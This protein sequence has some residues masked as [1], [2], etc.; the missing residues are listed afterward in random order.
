MIMYY[1]SEKWLAKS[2]YLSCE[3]FNPIPISHI[4]LK[5]PSLPKTLNQKKDEV[6]FLNGLSK[7][8]GGETPPILA[9]NA[10]YYRQR[11]NPQV[12]LER[13]LRRQIAH[14]EY[15]ALSTNELKQLAANYT[16]NDLQNLYF[17]VP[18]L[19]L[20]HGYVQTVMKPV[21]LGQITEIHTERGFYLKL[22]HNQNITLYP[23]S[24]FIRWL[25]L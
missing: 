12:P 2:P 24:K 14:Q 6:L 22:N 18:T 11:I 4:T 7:H 16:Q 5:D 8:F 19:K 10:D 15:I 1:P 21:Q 9:V 23:N 3:Q 25:G 17:I 20:N 13:M